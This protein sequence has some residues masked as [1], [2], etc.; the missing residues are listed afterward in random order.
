MSAQ[1]DLLER[2]PTLAEYTRMTLAV[3][4][5][6]FTNF[7]AVELALKNS[8]Y[9]VIAYD[10]GE[11]VGMARVVGDG[12]MFYYIQ[13]VAVVPDQRG[14]GLGQLLMNQIMAYLRA[15]APARAFIGLFATEGHDNFYRYYGFEQS[16]E[17]TGMY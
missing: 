16:P 4:W 3:G 5:E 11:I 15:N 13:D 8:L 7:A 17:L 9:H 2:A 1:Y 10:H 12:A 14:R 6:S